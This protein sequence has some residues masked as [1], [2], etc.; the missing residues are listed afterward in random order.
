MMRAALVLLL[1][2]LNFCL[3]VSAAEI[4]SLD[5]LLE[6]VTLAY[7]GETARAGMKGVRH[8][9]VTY[10]NMRKQEGRIIRTYQAPDRLR[11]E[12][13]YPDTEE[14]RI[15]NGPHAWKR[16][17]PMSTPFRDALMLQAMRM[18]LPWNLLQGRAQLRDLGMQAFEDGQPLRMLELPMSANLAIK[19]GVDPESGRIMRSLGSMTGSMVM[20]FGT[21]YEDFR[22]QDGRLYAAIEHHYVA[23][24]PTGHTRIEQVEFL[25]T[26][27]EESLFI[28]PGPE[29]KTR[30]HI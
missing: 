18:A 16:E 27:P 30:Q 25:D 19:V 3:P 7:G 4:D 29:A 6:K 15:L 9:G 13:Q 23:G 17:Q 22:T 24:Q 20:E 28:P 26:F 10:S 21:V 2:G 12:I 11:I 14:L 5:V 1:A 8:T